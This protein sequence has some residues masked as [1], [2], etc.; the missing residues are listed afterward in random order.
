MHGKSLSWAKIVQGERRTSSSLERYAE[1][2]L[3]YAK[4][5]ILKRPNT[6]HIVK[7]STLQK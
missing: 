6:K 1:P 4:V 5:T 3:S 2:K 7:L